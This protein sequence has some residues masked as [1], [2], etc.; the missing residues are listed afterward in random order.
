MEFGGGKIMKKFTAILIVLGLLAVAHP[1]FSSG[2]YQHQ[3][4]LCA[5]VTSSQPSA[6]VL[7]RLGKEFF[8][9]ENIR[10]VTDCPVAIQSVFTKGKD[11][12]IFLVSRWH[13][14]SSEETYTFSCQWIDPDGQAC[15]VSSASLETPEDLDSGIFF[16]YTA[17]IDMQSDLKEGE[18]TVNLLLNGDLVDAKDLTIASE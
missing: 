7:Q 5:S 4:A 9:Q 12:R 10:T 14:L 3:S 18:W 8:E 2:S 1:G 15:Y 16:T 17:Y 11:A 6:R 13:G